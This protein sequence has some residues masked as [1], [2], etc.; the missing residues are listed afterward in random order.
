M[1]PLRR[2]YLA[3]GMFAALVASIGIASGFL[4]E[5]DLGFIVNIAMTLS[6]VSFIYAFL[7]RCPNCRKRLMSTMRGLSHGLP[8]RKCQGCGYDLSQSSR[9]MISN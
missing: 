4:L 5:H 1:S 8:T 6:F 9:P 3:G 7:V 2:Y